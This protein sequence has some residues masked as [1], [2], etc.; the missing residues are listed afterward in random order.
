[1]PTHDGKDEAFFSAKALRHPIIE[2]LLVEE[3]GDAYIANDITIDADCG[4][5]LYGVNSVGK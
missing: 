5:L 2:R 1:M 3:K 4:T